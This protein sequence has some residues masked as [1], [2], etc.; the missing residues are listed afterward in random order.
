MPNSS[1]NPNPMPINNDLHSLSSAS[2]DLSNH[3]HAPPPLPPH[4]YA[5]MPINKNPLPPPRQEE[6]VQQPRQYNQ[7]RGN[8]RYNDT[9]TLRADQK[10][11]YPPPL[12]EVPQ[13]IVNGDLNHQVVDGGASGRPHF[14]EVHLDY[15]SRTAE[16]K[17]EPQ[18][19]TRIPTGHARRDNRSS[20]RMKHRKEMEQAQM[21]F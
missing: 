7:F 18:Q 15:D 1:V 3:H 5:N 2:P 4:N 13:F 6:P 11:E 14:R 20:L 9:Q 19:A 16:T 12:K 10:L 8:Q 21:R 17:A